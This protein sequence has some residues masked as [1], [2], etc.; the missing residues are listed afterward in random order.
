MFISNTIYC[1]F[2]GRKSPKSYYQKIEIWHITGAGMVKKLGIKF[3]RHKFFAKRELKIG[4]WGLA[5]R[6]NL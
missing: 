6:Q 3:K 1:L 4:V 2:I 5:H